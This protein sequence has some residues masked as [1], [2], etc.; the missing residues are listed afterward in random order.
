MDSQQNY[1]PKVVLAGAGAL[2]VAVGLF[3]FGPTAEP[4]IEQNSSDTT[5]AENTQIENEPQPLG[6]ETGDVA[7][8]TDTT[9]SYQGEEGKSALELLK[10]NVDAV[11]KES[12]FG[13][14]VD[15]INGIVGG[16]DGKYWL[17]YVNGE[18]AQIGAGEYITQ[19]GD[20]IEWRFE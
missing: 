20:V 6:A 7:A 11:T 2:L 10:I 1:L 9:V 15:S 18:M 17:F 3:V 16:T 8:E 5:A 19:T 12:S 14:Y 4:A 13:E